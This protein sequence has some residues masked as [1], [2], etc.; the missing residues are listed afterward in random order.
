VAEVQVIQR[1]L[2]DALPISAR[3]GVGLAE[4]VETVRK[5]LAGTSQQLTLRVKLSDGKA[6]SDL[7]KHAEVLDRRYVGGSVELDVVIGASTL[8]RLQVAHPQIHIPQP[9]I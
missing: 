1:K 9:A 6:I 5:L 3:T 4:V 2:P 8:H 7:E